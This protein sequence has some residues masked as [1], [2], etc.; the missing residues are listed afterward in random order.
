M[1]PFFR[2]LPCALARGVCVVLAAV[3]VAAAQAPGAR[4]EGTVHVRGS[5]APVRDATVAIEGTGLATRT[6]SLGRYVL[7]R[8]P[9]GPQVLVARRLGYAVSRI[10]V[11]VPAAG[12]RTIDVVMATSSLQ[13]DQLTVTADRTGRARGELGTASVID[14]DAIAN[15]IASSLQGVLELVPGVPLQ[16]PGLDGAAQFSLR[17]LATNST[18]GVGGISG[19]GAADIGAAG[20]LIVLDGVPLSNN[21]N[22]QSVGVRGE[23]VPVASTAGGGIDLRRIP[24]STLERVEVIRGIPS[25]RWG[26]LTQGAIIVDTRAAAT[27]PEL[28]MRFDP[29]TTEGNLVGGRGFQSDR[30]SLTVTGNI[31]QTASART[32]SSATTIRG[33]SQIAHRMYFGTAPGSRLSPDGRSPLP[34]L[35]FDTRLDWWQLKYSSPERPDVQVGRNSFQDDRGL[36]FSERAR[37]ALGGGTLEWTA[38]LDAQEQDTRESQIISRPTTPFTNRLTEG[39]NI[40]SYVEG[41]Y[42]GA[43]QLLGAPR[44]LYSRLEWERSARRERFGLAQFRVGAEARREW[45]D[46][47]GYLF[48]ISRPPQASTFNGTAGY[49]RPRRFSD[50]PAIATSAVYADTRFALR[51]GEMTAELQPGV[52]LETLHD[53]AWWT[54]APRSAMVQPRLTA[55]IA[56]WPWLRLRGGAGVVSKSPTVAQLYPARQYYDLVNVNRFTPDP[57]ER[58]AVVTTFIRDPVNPALGLSR[59]DKREAGFELDGGPRRGSISATWFDDRIA[60]AVTLR[61]D[62]RPLQRARYALADTGRGTGQ[63]GRI[64]DP[65]IRFEPVP[66][67]LD[68]YVNSGS[69]DSRGVE[70]TVAFPV[71]PALRT[72]L[73]ASGAAITTDF[74]TDDRDYGPSLRL[75]D[76]QVDTAIKR[77]AYFDGASTRSK[78]AILTWRLVHQQPDLGLVITATIQQRLGDE[79]LV[80]SRTDSLAF[81]GYIL[82]DGTLV[83]VAENDKLRPEFADL[84]KLRPATGASRSTQPDDW[85]MSLQVAKSLGRSGR[86]SFYIFNVLDKFVTYGSS[87]SIR[88]LPSTRFGAELTIP[89]SELFGGAK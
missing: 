29:R 64:V 7:L 67:F 53:G 21:A 41:P 24:A 19:P 16:P 33:A 79:R 11:S 51:R 54:T 57:R 61:R 9:A 18:A 42:S 47:D 13:L 69:L 48:D 66:V 22:L 39:R 6:D 34:R 74:A 32:L 28:A 27:P 40:G 31:A 78:R 80:L 25:A 60:G 45:N 58:L 70:F 84:R 5:T 30:Q 20:T 4:I 72:R 15:Q 36:R 82:R 43:Y 52:R 85:L 89:T 35:S 49:D 65:P 46:G 62:P 83:P 76:F 77:I 26:D 50:T 44:L 37:L 38:A 59:A 8:V 14:R 56:P 2:H 23:T 71:V 63:P 1:N 81:N 68:R 12:T 75:N 10:P 88:A 3:G 73:E 55:Q 17:A 86:L 87:G